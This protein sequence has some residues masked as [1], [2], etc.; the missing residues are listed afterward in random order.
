MDLP[1]GHRAHPVTV[2]RPGHDVGGRDPTVLAFLQRRGVSRRAFLAFCGAMAAA[3]A[4]PP[5]Y[6]ARIAKALTAAPRLPIIWL[7]GQDCAGDT[8]GFLRASHPTVAELIL[9]TLAVDYHETIMA[10]AGHAAERSLGDTV[11]AFK[12]Q[13]IAIV[14]GAVPI[15]EDGT[16]CLIGG[17]TFRSMVEDVCGNALLTITVGSCAFDGGL[18][19][20]NGGPTGATGVANIVPRAKVVNLPGCP[21]NVQNLTATIVH[22][23]TFGALPATDSLSR[24]Y[25]AYGQ[26]LHDQCERRA[27]FDAGEYVLA[28]GDEG[29]RKGWCLYKMGCKGP[30]TFANCPTVRFNDRTSWPVKAGHG[31][32]GCTM[33]RFWDQMSPFYRRLSNPPGFAVDVTADQLGLG[34]VGA[35]T[36]LSVAHGTVSYL[37]TRSAR[38]HEPGD[39]LG[40]GLG[41]EPGPAATLTPPPDP[42]ERQEGD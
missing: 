26:L 32:V 11:G 1:T 38:G 23:L 17:R 36:A 27:H 40:A 3:L 4:L 31:C 14:E 21:T 20:A 16:Y 25:F 2:D 29:A 42:T 15:A 10:P 9:D 5:W 8:E 13:Y 7:E 39:Q 18:S 6:G 19:A 12:G 35:V 41:P 33:P 34:L 37:R 28:W 24:P 22:Y 30:E